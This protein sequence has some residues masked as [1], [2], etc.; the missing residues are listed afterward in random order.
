MRQLNSRD[1]Q[2][3]IYALAISHGYEPVKPE[4]VAHEIDEVDC[5]EFDVVGVSD[6]EEAN[7]EHQNSRADVL[8]K[9]LGEG[10][11]VAVSTQDIKL[12]NFRSIM[13]RVEDITNTVR[14]KHE[15]VP[16]IYILSVIT[17]SRAEDHIGLLV[18]DGNKR[19]ITFID[20]KNSVVGSRIETLF[21]SYSEER[22]FDTYTS[23]SVDTQLPADTKT[24]GYH[25]LTNI[26]CVLNLL[27]E[28]R[29]IEQSTIKNKIKEL[30]EGSL[31]HG[32][33]LVNKHKNDSDVIV[34][35]QFDSDEESTYVTSS[36]A[37]ATNEE[38]SAVG[39]ARDRRNRWQKAFDYVYSV[40]DKEHRV[41][42]AFFSLPSI[43]KLPVN[44]LKIATE[45]LPR[46]LETVLTQKGYIRF[47]IIPKTARIILR[48]I[49]SPMNSMRAA[50]DKRKD[51]A[52][53]FG[54]KGQI[55]GMGLMFLSGLFTTIAYTAVIVFTGGLAGISIGL[56]FIGTG[57]AAQIISGLGVIGKVLGV[58]TVLTGVTV[59]ASTVVSAV[60]HALN[61][62]AKFFRK[63]IKVRRQRLEEQENALE[64]KDEVESPLTMQSLPEVSVERDGQDQIK[65]ILI[66]KD[67]NALED[68]DEVKSPLTMQSLPEV[69]VERDEQDQLKSILKFKKQGVRPSDSEERR[70]S[71]EIIEYQKTKYNN[72]YGEDPDDEHFEALTTDQIA[73]IK[74]L[75][76]DA[77]KTARYHNDFDKWFGFLCQEMSKTKRTLIHQFD[78]N[79]CYEDTYEINPLRDPRG[80]LDAYFRGLHPKTNPKLTPK[81]V[82]VL[83]EDI[84]EVAVKVKYNPNFDTWLDDRR[85]RFEIQGVYFAP[86]ESMTEELYQFFVE[87]HQYCRAQH[88]Q[89]LFFNED[90]FLE[91]KE[92]AIAIANKKPL[93]GSDKKSRFK[94]KEF[95]QKVYEDLKLSKDE[96]SMFLLEDF[97]D[98]ILDVWRERKSQMLQKEL[99]ARHFLSFFEPKKKQSKVTFAEHD[100][101]FGSGLESVDEVPPT[102]PQAA[103]DSSL[104]ADE[105]NGADEYIE[106]DGAECHTP[107][108]PPDSLFANRE[109]L[110]GITEIEERSG[111]CA[112]V[113]KP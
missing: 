18:L 40:K 53:S 1:I 58:S 25:L 78:M 95:C 90:R 103:L 94:S 97:Q 44:I 43:F 72:Y 93:Y 28:S 101:V 12:E 74:D 46:Y 111:G 102:S 22:L 76:Q 59:A 82:A 108:I 27:E 107:S 100:H 55:L 112:F 96:S 19:A 86:E 84:R 79:Y 56:N 73:K 67:K 51:L 77:A 105:A 52:K 113:I 35:S 36:S 60:L 8:F 30:R 57:V 66:E 81:V 87:C 85:F 42:E 14:D 104:D 6:I 7:A 65:S 5:D 71:Q 38:S 20:S 39:V 48:T 89:L 29:A 9:D 63:K 23:F 99:T 110:E 10:V 88:E 3:A 50:N 92:Q 32:L 31:V 34:D 4:H 41:R 54:A 70:K 24:C 109:G 83:K 91:I 13:N 69:S 106:V 2:P 47:A 62:V 98:I 26:D 33:E 17:K 45:C 64:D 80:A 16:K 15:I 49:T 21:K 11:S 37:A 75:A 61:R 68:K